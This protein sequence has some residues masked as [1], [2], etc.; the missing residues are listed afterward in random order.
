M[1][2]RGRQ[3]A[4][5]TETAVGEVQALAQEGQALTADRSRLAANE[6]A[7][8]SALSRMEGYERDALYYDGDPVATVLC[9][10]LQELSGL[11]KPDDET[12]AAACARA[13]ER[14]RV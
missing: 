11:D 12:F 14:C 3:R 5:D 8:R 10:F 4:R 1:G 7:T 2:L 9:V 13:E 6:P